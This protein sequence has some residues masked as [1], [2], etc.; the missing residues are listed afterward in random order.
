M[1]QKFHFTIYPQECDYKGLATLRTIGNHLLNAAGM[2][3][4]E[5]SFGIELIQAQNLTWV[6]SRLTIEMTRYPAQNEYIEIETWIEDCNKITS[7]RN[8]KIYDS[9]QNIIGYACALWAMIDLATRRPTN[10]LEWT[11][12]IQHIIPKSLPIERPVRIGE[13][14]E[15]AQTIQ[16]TVKYSD[17]DMNEHSNSM[18]YIEWMTDCLPLERFRKSFIKRCDINYMHETV[19]GDEIVIAFT[20]TPD[21]SQFE[22]KLADGKSCCKAQFCWRENP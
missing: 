4:K 9:Q 20:D 15:N 14:H 17:I 2:A 16:H 13:L 8:F 10:L 7:A 19:F 22:V 21:K 12:F 18:K 11:D 6:L 5:L 1:A 3:A